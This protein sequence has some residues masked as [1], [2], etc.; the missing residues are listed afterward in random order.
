MTL[1]KLIRLATTS[2]PR[3]AA[4]TMVGLCLTMALAQ[5]PAGAQTAS[6]TASP[7]G[8]T[9]KDGTTSAKSGRGAC[10]RHGGIAKGAASSAVATPTSTAGTSTAAA[11]TATSASTPAAAPSNSAA[12]QARPAV[13]PGG[14]SGQ[15]WV[16]TA[17][18]V[19]HCSGDRWYGKTK[20]GQYMSEADAKAQGNHP[21]HGKS[22]S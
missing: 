11:A 4:A 1:V 13:A 2:R 14:G 20:Q 12:G 17:S 10:S 15:V 7:S 16:N 19:Y 3:V 8:V 5:M 21:D 9:C 6:P 22:C 18:K